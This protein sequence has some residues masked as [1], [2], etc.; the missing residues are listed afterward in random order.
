MILLLLLFVISGCL[1]HN[2]R[3]RVVRQKYG[4]AE[5]VY[6]SHWPMEQKLEHEV[7]TIVKAFGK[8]HFKKPQNAFL[9][10]ETGGYIEEICGEKVHINQTVATI[11][12][13][14]PDTLVWPVVVVLEPEISVEVYRSIRVC[15]S[16]FQTWFGGG[17]RGHNIR[18]AA[19]SINNYLL[20]PGEL[21][22]FNR[23]TGPRTSE[24]GYQQAPIIVGG[25]VVPG[26]GGGVCQVSSTLYNTVKKA[27]LEIV[28]RFP[29]SRPVDYV[30]RGRDATVSDFLD[31][32]FRNNTEE[33]LL[34]KTSAYNFHLVIEL[35]H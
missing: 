31:F 21:F 17:G 30:P 5:G 1:A 26:Y 18:L 9:D 19:Q 6:F 14:E 33:Y 3:D 11:M 7:E 10:Q 35:W 23:A 4:V 34:I 29:H 8:E 25:S 24:R 2:I 28:E 13:A 27:D 22:S 32:K 20:A 15:K 16:S 12:N